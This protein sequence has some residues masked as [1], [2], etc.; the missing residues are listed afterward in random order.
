MLNFSKIF[1]CNHKNIPSWTLHNRNCHLSMML[2][3]IVFT[4]IVQRVVEKIELVLFLLPQHFSQSVLWPSSGV[5]SLRKEKHH[6]F[7]FS[8]ENDSKW[9]RYV[10]R[11]MEWT[12]SFRTICAMHA[13]PFS[14]T[15]VTNDSI[16][17][18]LSMDLLF[19]SFVCLA[20][21]TTRA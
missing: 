21:K 18:F 3:P 8:P 7:F 4:L 13:I 14:A 5:K 15:C 11:Y 10:G 9:N 16:F 6:I 2:A 19:I 20:K 12:N 1:Y 17:I